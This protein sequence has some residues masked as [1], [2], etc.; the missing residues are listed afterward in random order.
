MILNIRRN[1]REVR[2]KGTGTPARNNTLMNE[3]PPNPPHSLGVDLNFLHR[4]YRT[5]LILL[6][7]VAIFLFER[8]LPKSSLGWMVGGLLNLGLLAG[9]EFS[10]RKFVQPGS[11]S[12]T[13]MTG[14]LVGKLLFATAVLALVMWAAVNK[15]I[16]PVWVLLGFMMPHAVLILKLVG[17]KLRSLNQES[18]RGGR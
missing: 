12:L 2:H 5:S 9:V 6:L 4:V 11:K 17:Q 3:Q 18:E 15:W 1:R 10:I 7:L 8:G 14:L 13:P 16:N